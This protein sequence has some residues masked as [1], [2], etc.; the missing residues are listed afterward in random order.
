MERGN[1]DIVVK[2][3]ALLLLWLVGCALCQA[4]VVKTIDRT[5]DPV[6]ET[7]TPP[8]TKP[9]N[10][11]DQTAKTNETN[12]TGSNNQGSKV[13]TLSVSTNSLSFSASGGTQTINVT[14]SQPWQIST[15]TYSWVHL[16]KYKSQLTVEVDRNDNTSTRT[17][18]FTIKSGN[19]TQRVDISQ[20]AKEKVYTLSVS[21]SSLS[22]PAS[23]GTQT[24][25]VTSSQPWQID[26]NTNSWGHL[27][28]NGS[29]LTVKI[30]PNSNTSSRTDYFVVKSGNITRRVDI[31]QAAKENSLSVSSSSLSFPASGGS[32]TITVS[33][34]Q[35]WKT[36]WV[37]A[38]WIHV[39]EY[40]SYI[41]VTID[42]NT[43]TSSRA[44]WFTIRSGDKE[45]RIDI[46]QSGRTTTTYPSYSST[47]RPT[48]SYRHYYDTGAVVQV[49]LEVTDFS[50]NIFSTGNGNVIHYN[51]GLSVKFGHHRTPVQFELGIKPGILWDMEDYDDDDEYGTVK[52]RMPIYARLKINLCN[53]G[54]NGKL[55]IS[56]M[57]YYNAIRD[58][59]YENRF[60]AGGGMGFAWRHWDWQTLY[61][62]QDVSRDT[63]RRDRFLGTALIYYF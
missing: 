32:Q 50:W 2:G 21:S 4:Q 7:V 29:Q 56:G 19:K 52:F 44:D 40:G 18:Y 43:K 30:D 22:F 28:K 25:T 14:S 49:G 35:N 16:N 38:S 46:S 20:A 33:S 17:A 47:V 60:S 6:P 63:W 45:Q 48:N 31:S 39:K 55:Y 12:K 1:A 41:T 5:P 27:T 36:Y 61:Y 15:D 58:K 42:A 34:S 10:N 9:D 54:D 59:H 26:V 53:V 23:G 13:Y 37:T 3:I 24:I 57:A 11:T 51:F 8:D 62:K